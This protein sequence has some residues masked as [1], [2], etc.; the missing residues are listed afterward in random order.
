MLLKITNL[1]QDDLAVVVEPYADERSVAHEK[2][3]TISV[4][5][6]GDEMLEVASGDVGVCVKKG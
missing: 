2:Q 5:I 6:S 3:L 4:R 1:D